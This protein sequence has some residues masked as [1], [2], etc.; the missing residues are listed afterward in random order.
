MDTRSLAFFG[1]ASYAV[2]DRLSVSVGGRWTRDE[3]EAYVFKGNYL[4]VGILGPNAVPFQI[5][6]DYT[7]ERDFSEFTPRL[8]AT[9]TLFDDFNVYAAYGR[10]FKSGGFDMRGDVSVTPA[11]RNG[12]DPE[13][14]DS[15]EAGFKS[16]LFD[17]RL[18]LNAAAFHA[19]YDGQ[20]VTTQVPVGNSAVSSIDNVGSSR[21]NGAEVEGTAVLADWLTANFS[22][23]Y[24]DAKFEEFA[25]FVAGAPGNG[26]PCVP[27]PPSP[28][29]A[30]GCYADVSDFRVFQNTP[31]WNGSIGLTARRDLGNAGELTL[32]AVY[33]GRSSVNLFETPIPALD[34]DGYSLVDANLVWTSADEHWRVGLHGRNVLDTRYKTGGYNFPTPVF[35]NS[36][37]S[38]YGPPQTARLTVEYRF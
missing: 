31:E 12:Y 29:T 8:S 22:L 6:T 25:A 24:V 13:I 16:Y 18:Q 20:L 23:G 3:K 34:Q 11:T 2:T 1:D 32:N 14:V 30:I 17:R 5:L 35:G 4:G 38:F 15:Y 27:N 37:I 7:N 21:I 10:G 36:V 26:F 33:S 19:K 28:P 9:Y